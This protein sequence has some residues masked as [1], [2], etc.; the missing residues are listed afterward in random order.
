MA[1]S[2]NKVLCSTGAFIGRVNNRNHKLIVENASKINCDGFELMMYSESWIEKIDE[3]VK[4]LAESKINF[5]SMHTNKNVGELISRNEAGDIEQAIKI[6]EANCIVASQLG[7]KLLVLH[8]WGGV[9]SDKHIDVNFRIYKDLLEIANKYE[10]LLT[11]ENIVCNTY[12]ALIHMKKLYE[13]YPND[14]KFTVD[15]RQAEFHELLEETCGSDFLWENNLVSHIHISDYSGGYM[16]WSKLNP[17]LAPGMG[18]INFDKFF[19]FLKDINYDKTITL[20]SPVMSESGIDIER[21]NKSLA[22]I[23]DRI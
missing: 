21:L 1:D 15:T 23:Y 16:D 13:M 3:I 6:F 10:L 18:H 8:L 4:D 11:V 7:I 17:V 22:F 20:E 2:K 9:P 5:V 14:I 19:G 12:N